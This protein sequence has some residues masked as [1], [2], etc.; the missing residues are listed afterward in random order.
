ME[1]KKHNGKRLVEKIKNGV[2]Y[3]DKCIET[4]LHSR[5]VDK[6]LS[7]CVHKITKLEFC[8]RKMPMSHLKT[9]ELINKFKA[10]ERRLSYLDLDNYSTEEAKTTTAN[11]EVLNTEFT[12]WL[13]KFELTRMLINKAFRIHIT[14]NELSML[15]GEPVKVEEI[16]RQCEAAIVKDHQEEG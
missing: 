12:T 5:L 2:K 9:D 13:K 14:M 7:F 11:I 6:S 4:F 1:S 16:M 8:N 15:T 3:I 10:E